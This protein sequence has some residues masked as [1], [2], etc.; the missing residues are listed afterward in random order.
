MRW[1]RTNRQ[2]GARLAFVALALQLV[3]TFGHV[4]ALMANNAGTTVSASQPGGWSPHDGG[5]K[6]L[7]DFDCPTCAL[8]Q[9]SAVS[10]PSVAPELPLPDAVDFIALRP[11]IELA[12][13][14]TP[15]AS[16]QAR[17]PPAV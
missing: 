4:H 13:A 14:I 10:A 3:L 5:N 7:A 8:I 15:Q 1:F 9:L 6:G 17:A 16:F 2:F 11:R 12:T